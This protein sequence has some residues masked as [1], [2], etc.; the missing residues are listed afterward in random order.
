MSNTK[1]SVISTRD[2]KVLL[3][4]GLT[5]LKKNRKK[6]PESAAGK[7]E[8]QINAL[9][10]KLANR[11]S[12][13]DLYDAAKTLNETLEK[14]L[15]FARKSSTREL[16]ESVV[17]AILIAGLLR[18]FVLD[19]FK[20]PSGSMIP[21]L[22]VGDHL[23]VSKFIYGLRSPVPMS[24]KWLVR[25]GSPQRGDVIVFRYPVDQT[26]DYIKRVVAVAGDKVRVFGN[27]VEINGALLNRLP[28]EKYIFTEDRECPS[29]LF[30]GGQQ[31]G[32]GRF[33]QMVDK[34]EETS[35]GDEGHQYSIIYQKTKNHKELPDDGPALPGLDCS[36]ES[37][38]LVEDDHVLVMGDNRD[39]SSDGRSWGGVP[40]SYVK[41]KAL[42]IFGSRAIDSG[43]RWERIGRMVR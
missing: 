22:R 24:N 17:I 19:P 1:T 42:F 38:C 35:H 33:E 18:A 3:K 28:V 27:K 13:S 12:D 34:F 25:W 14:E 31:S 20:I 15:G 7:V 32:I 29:I 43:V 41:G 39:N 4:E 30:C 40:T 9:K 8:D 37:Y 6:I 10:A 23:F 2:A 11:V 16:V 26:K 5:L 21:T 36:S